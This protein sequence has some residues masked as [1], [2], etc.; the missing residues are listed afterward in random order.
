MRAVVIGF[1]VQGRKRAAVAGRD[2]VAIVDPVSPEAQY[3]SLTDVAL[4]SYDAA[5]V[6]VPDEAKPELVRYLLEN[7][8][9]VLV[10]KPLITDDEDTLEQLA[11]LATETGVTCYTAYN[12]RFEPHFVRM[13]Q[14][15]ESG[16]LGAIYLCRMFYGNGTARDV[17]NSPWRDQGAGVLSDLGSHVLDTAL[18]WFGAPDTPFKVWSANRFENRAFDHVSFGSKGPPVLELEVALVSWRNHFTADVYGEKGSAHI[19]SLCKWGPSIF[20]RRTRVLPSGTPREE[21]VTLLHPDPTWS[22]EYDHF[23]ALCSHRMCGN[24]G[25]ARILNRLLNDLSRRA[26]RGEAC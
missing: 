23:R 15:I 22:L 11:R 3:R 13:K 5:L 9:H 21:A 20:S 26:V 2:V 25:D 19:S 16:E 7:G 10:E 4:D 8:K 14:T 17:R 1:G 6:C 18:F 24:I 12:H